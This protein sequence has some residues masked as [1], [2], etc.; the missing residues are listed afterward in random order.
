M[1]HLF[2]EGI[3]NFIFSIIIFECSIHFT[4]VNDNY[5]SINFPHYLYNVK[6]LFSLH[7]ISLTL[8]YYFCT[9]FH[10]CMTVCHYD[11]FYFINSIPSVCSLKYLFSVDGISLIFSF[12]FLCLFYFT[13]VYDN[14]QSLYL[15]YSLCLYDLRH[16][17]SVLEISLFFLIISTHINIIY[18]LDS[19]LFT[20]PVSKLFVLHDP[21][22]SVIYFPIF[23]LESV[24]YIDILMHVMCLP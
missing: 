4:S 12:S 18:L 15:L 23:I 20:Y 17:L 6:H 7:D 14:S 8:P 24:C 3:S 19:H 13:S 22:H 5:C 16:L 1:K 21:L 2:S 11:S 9:L 10:F